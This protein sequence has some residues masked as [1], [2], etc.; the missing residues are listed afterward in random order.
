M[1]DLSDEEIGALE[2]CVKIAED[3]GFYELATRLNLALA[4][5]RPACK[6]RVLMKDGVAQ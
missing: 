5:A 2:R 6:I 3:Y 1:I 4:E